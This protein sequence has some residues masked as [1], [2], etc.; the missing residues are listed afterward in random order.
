MGHLQ[1]PRLGENPL[2]RLTDIS[3]AR[4]P[5]MR[6][7]AGLGRPDG[8]P[9]RVFMTALADPGGQRNRGG[10]ICS[11]GLGNTSR[12]RGRSL[13]PAATQSRSAAVWTDKSLP[14][15]VP[16]QEPVGPVS[17]THLRAHET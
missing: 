10:P 14:S 12:L 9:F 6:K 11:S 4:A 17:Y 8:S 13:N 2:G 7:S 1:S 3:V 16:A 5:E 15:E